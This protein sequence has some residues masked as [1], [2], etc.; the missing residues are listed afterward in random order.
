M[1]NLGKP[2][3]VKMLAQDQPH[4]VPN[5]GKSTGGVQWP[6]RGSIDRP[7]PGRLCYLQFAPGLNYCF[8]YDRR[9]IVSG[10]YLHGSERA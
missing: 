3:K 1:G 7:T 9:S 10:T 5:L 6:R 4:Q 2:G 8:R